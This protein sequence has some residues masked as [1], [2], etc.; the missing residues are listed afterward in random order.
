M[1]WLLAILCLSALIVIHEFGHYACARIGGMHVDRFSVLGIGPVLLRLGTYKGTEFVISAIPFGAYVHIVG[2]EPERRR[3]RRDGH[4]APRRLSQLP[5]Q[6]RVG[7]R[8]RHRRRTAV[9]L[10]HRDAHH[11]RHRR[12]HR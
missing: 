10:P 12:L 8:P 2:M 11:R 1:S 6:P 4:P 7:A 5:R 3:G 9:Q